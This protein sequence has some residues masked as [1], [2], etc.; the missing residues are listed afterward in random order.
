MS[1]VVWLHRLY[2]DIPAL[3][4]RLDREGRMTGLTPAWR[5]LLGWEPSELEGRHYS[6]VLHPD[7][8]ET[9]GGN[10]A[11]AF[12]S[13]SAPRP[14]EVQNR[15]ADGT[16]RWFRWTSIPPGSDGED[17]LAVGID[18]TELREQSVRAGQAR[19]ELK[20]AFEAIPSYVTLVNLAGEIT[21][22]NRTYPGIT[23]EQVVGTH[24]LN[25]LP[26]ADRPKMQAAI[27][28][29]VHGADAA[30]VVVRGSGEDGTPTWYRS[31]LAPLK[32]DGEPYGILVAGEDI[33]LAKRA[34]VHSRQAARLAAAGRVTGAL[35]HDYNNLVMSMVVQLEL[36][37]LEIADDHAL[38]PAVDEL[39]GIAAEA[40]AATQQLLGTLRHAP[41]SVEH[42][43]TDEHLLFMKPLLSRSAG[44]AVVL[45]F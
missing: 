19:V 36:M 11:R 45:A 5:L 18:V 10:F 30:E 14:R 13:G 22:I 7:E 8:L 42:C 44:D 37:R 27:D 28:A 3:I 32:Q 43:D 1:D 2:A 24:L 25:W 41:S 40:A 12:E 29:V 26:P 15:H 33:T 16:C 6:F 4:V 23:K 34:E 17:V 9:A 38:A 39:H 31:R 20:A 21:Y 35:A